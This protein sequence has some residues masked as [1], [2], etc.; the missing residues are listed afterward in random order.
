MI[1]LAQRLD[2]IQEPQTIKMAKLGRELRAQ[3]APLIDLSLGEPDFRTPDFICEAANAA[4]AEGRTKY[5]PVAGIPELRQAICAKLKRDNGLNYLPEETIVSTGAKQALANIILCLINP[6]DEVIIPTPFWVTY[7]AL[8]LLAEGTPVYVHCPV[9][10]QF[11]LTPEQLEAAITPKTKMFIFS[12]P[13]NPTGTVYSR[14]ELAALAEVFARHPQVVIVSDEIYEY[15]NYAGGH[16]SIAQF[17]AV[18][19]RVVVVN[20][21]SKGFAMTGW[22]LGYLAAPKYMVQACE[23]LQS[24]FTSGANVISQY[25]GVTALT[26]PLD[27]TH[28]M[29]AAFQER[30][31]FVIGRL[32]Q[33]PRLNVPVPDGAFYAFP[34]VSAYFG[35][36]TP[37]GMRIQTDEDVSMYLLNIAHV[38]T[39][40]GAAFG[41]DQ[42]IRMSYATGMDNLREALSRMADAFGKLR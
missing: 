4:M 15:I 35:T 42:C 12:S 16:Q 17:D 38:N 1:P 31:D 25:A 33:I 2:R 18:R 22:R 24:Q 34:D 32:Q 36:T 3:G 10:Q 21:F 5:P 41:D 11:K 7:G 9:A 29:T 20:G 40:Y 8:V 14:E 27:A 26:Q 23:K 37:D 19:D 28:A 13:C 6:G 39:V 30:R